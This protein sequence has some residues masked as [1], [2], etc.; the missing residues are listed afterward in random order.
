[1]A[2]EYTERWHH[3]QHIRD[4]VHR[5]GQMER[6]FLHPILTTFA[7]SLPVAMAD[8]K[9]P[10][11]ST[12]HL[13][14]KGEAGGDWTVLRGE[15]TWSLYSGSPELPD[16]RVIMKQGAAWRLYTRGLP[17]GTVHHYARIQG[18]EGLAR[19]LLGAVAI[20]A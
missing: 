5:P 6:R 13:R 11:G 1:V 17:P 7:H 9:A 18:D 20:I 4:A 2:R 16:V 10:P 14:V 19:A 3:Q 12:I 8:A 15:E